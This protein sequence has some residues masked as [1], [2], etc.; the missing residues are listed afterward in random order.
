MVTMK[1]GFWMLGEPEWTIE[2]IAQHARDWG[3][4]GVDL[5]VARRD[6]E[7]Q[8]GAFELSVESADADLARISTSFE[9]AGVEIASLMCNMRSPKAD[10]AESWTEFEQEFTRHARLAETVGSRRVMICPVQ[11]TAAGPWDDYLDRIWASVARA[12]DKTP[13]VTSVVIQNHPG[14]AN[15]REVLSSAERCG[16]P[17]FGCEFSCDHVVVMQEDTF[18][19]IDRY[20]PHVHKICFADR[21]LPRDEELGRYDGHYFRVKFE[22]AKYGEGIVQS[23]R[24]FSELAEHGFSDYVAYKCE[25]ASRPGALLSASEGLMA[26]FPDFMRQLGAPVGRP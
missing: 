8:R 3:Y 16:D 12:L 21:S 25:P 11:P 20:A 1:L 2:E 5:R 4:D 26:G 23:E 17:R 7:Q 24:L 22:I 13:S 15:A 10:E 9:R 6:G 18:A 14:R 19:L